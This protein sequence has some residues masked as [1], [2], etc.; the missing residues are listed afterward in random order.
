MTVTSRITWVAALLIVGLLTGSPGRA[1]DTV[2]V[3]AGIHQGFVRI[4]FDWGRAIDYRARLDGRKLIVTFPQSFTAGFAPLRRHLNKY[5]RDVTQSAD[6]RTVTFFLKNDFTLKSDVYDNVV[7]LDLRSRAVIAE[8]SGKTR[9]V[10]VRVG[11]H[12]G[13]SRLVFDYTRDTGYRVD[14]TGETIRIDLS[15]PDPLDLSRLDKDPPR[16]VGAAKARAQNNRQIV[17]LTVPAEARVRHF[18]DGT[19]IV[20]DVI[21]RPNRNG[22]NDRQVAAKQTGPAKKTAQPA[23]APKRLLP[24]SFDPN[25][26]IA[27][28]PK[29]AAKPPEAKPVVSK[30]RPKAADTKSA[31]EPSAPATSSGA[32][33]VTKAASGDAVDLTFSWPG[34]VKAAVFERAGFL[35]AVFDS[36]SGETFQPN[37]QMARFV[38]SYAKVPRGDATIYRFVLNETVSASVH[39][40]GNDWTVRL[41][42]GNSQR[43][44][45]EIQVHREPA[46]AVGPRV[47]LPAGD[48]GKRIT[49]IDPEV[50]DTLEVIPVGQPGAGIG[51][52]IEFAE[53]VLLKSAQGIA[54]LPRT[55]RLMLTE[56]R[57]GLEVTSPGGLRLSGVASQETGA[58]ESGPVNVYQ[59]PKSDYLFNYAAWRLADAK[60]F[61][62]T[63]HILQAAVSQANP[64]QRNK[65]RLKLARFFFAH[66][67]PIDAIGVLDRVAD[68]NA[69]VLDDPS[70]LSLRGASRVLAKRYDE[71][72]E[73][74]NHKA[75]QGYPEVQLWRG[76]ALTSN[77]AWVDAKKA[78]EDGG[79]V[80]TAFPPEPRTDFRLDW[81]RA[82]VHTHESRRALVQV[83]K[84]EQEAVNK[85]QR[86]WAMLLRAAANEDMGALENA[87][88]GY[89]LVAA[90]DHRPTRA[91]AKLGRIRVLLA[92]NQMSNEDAI[93]ALEN[94]RYTWR[95]D[96]LE[97]DL[98]HRLGRLYIAEKNYRKGLEVMRQAVTYYPQSR[99]APETARDMNEEFARLFLDGGA[100]EL[101]P[102]TALGLFNDFRELTP[103]GPQGDEVIRRLAD[104]LVSVDLLDQAA[105]LLEHQVNYRLKGEDKA[106]VA[107]RL[108]VIRLLDRDP[109]KALSALQKSQ[110]TPLPDELARERRRLESRALSDLDRYEEALA[111]L[112]DDN[113]RAAQSLRAEIYWRWKKWPEAATAFAKLLEKSW[114]SEDKIDASTRRLVMQRAVSLSL[115][116]KADELQTLRNRYAR[117]VTATPDEN[118]FDVITADVDHTGTNFRQLAS[119][120]AQISELETFMTSYRQKLSQGGL[121]AI[122]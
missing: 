33:T 68:K 109:A 61:L 104:R 44:L 20:V 28:K 114:E 65:A 79:A 78:F 74:L 6:G 18:R 12:A 14:K 49:I 91:R 51:N 64:K 41:N 94:L 19:K 99:L 2:D 10:G 100:D 3:R 71:A 77:H 16:F 22:G 84:A 116:N 54:V 45:A 88:E 97:L 85:P 29:L 24:E 98:L 82:L 62:E 23:K 4:A 107:S 31:E 50:G 86:Q 53:F 52:E 70:Y 72:L 89:E 76:R 115:A 113:G 108:A 7:A 120:I 37:S 56:L 40:Q 58:A 96:D 102:V 46:A 111:A 122:N 119:T 32:V 1:A 42:N 34:P 38:A 106:R 112:A 26:S 43:P 13:Y 35:W 57:T 55:D 93:E 5:V 90:D 17:E 8:N 87:L 63:K 73:D 48:V 80:L 67:F 11:E 66:G 101:E 39:R 92:Q 83:S 105:Q 59:A 47:F 95:G 15:R 21:F 9:A 60:E 81:A 121:S 36:E 117:H 27:K 30:P 110:W 69:D 118:A 25:K 103:M 75:L